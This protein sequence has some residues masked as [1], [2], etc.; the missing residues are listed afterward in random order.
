[1]STMRAGFVVPEASGGRLEIRETTI[2]AAGPGQVLVRVKASGLN[3]GEILYRHATRKGV[4]YIG[5]V[6]FAGEVVEPGAGSR[7][8]APGD[9]VM[10]HG[11]A[12]QAEFVVVED[13]ALMKIPDGIDWFTAAAFPNVF[14]TAHDAVMTAGGFRAG[15]HV[16]VNAAPSGIGMAAIQIAR[17]MGAATV[18]GT[19]RNAARLARIAALGLTHTVVAE[20]RPLAH[21]P[22]RG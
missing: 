6:E 1:M 22:H 20:G 2:P 10:G 16:L 15:D 5:G 9:R 17:V 13:R 12:T 21:V 7:G 18:V 8:F 11:A 14:I 19:S 4:P 3:R